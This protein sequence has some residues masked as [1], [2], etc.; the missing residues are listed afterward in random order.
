M[1]DFGHK[2]DYFH[3][4]NEKIRECIIR[5]DQDITLKAYKSELFSLEQNLSKNFVS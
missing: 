3:E 4:D 2:I 5:F 1:I